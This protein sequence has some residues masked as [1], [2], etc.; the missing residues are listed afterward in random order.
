V[1][2]LLLDFDELPDKPAEAMPILRFRLRKLVAFDVEDAAVS[3]QIVSRNATSVRTVI[4]ITPNAVIAE[5]ESV[6]R[7]AGYEPGAILPSSLAALATVDPEGGSL[8]VNQNGNSITTAITNHNDVLLYRTLELDASLYSLN[9]TPH[10]ELQSEAQLR[11]ADE[12]HQSVSVAIAYFEDTMGAPP[13]QL[14]ACGLGGA[15]TLNRLVG[16]FMIP[17]R[18][19]VATPSIG[20]TTSIPRGAIAGVAGALTS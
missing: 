19:L 13:Q 3:C 14:L 8:L 10:D 20:N 9:G 5:Y 4:A 12:L 11:A 2:V 1:R 17:V 15:E 7:E 6:V 16:D 18:D